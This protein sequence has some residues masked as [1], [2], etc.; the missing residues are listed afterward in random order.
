MK[1]YSLWILS[2]A[3]GRIREVFV[4]GKDPDDVF[5]IAMKRLD[6]EERIVWCREVGEKDR[7]T[8]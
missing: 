5:G 3:K 2:A 7:G 1:K 6:D 4:V 8:A